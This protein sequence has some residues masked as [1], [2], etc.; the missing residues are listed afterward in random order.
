[1]IELSQTCSLPIQ[2]KLLVVVC[3]VQ[4]TENIDMYPPKTLLTF[5]PL[6][7]DSEVL[8]S[9]GY[10]SPY[11]WS[12]T[13]ICNCYITTVVDLYIDLSYP[14]PFGELDPG[15]VFLSVVNICKRRGK[16]VGSFVFRDSIW[17][18]AQGGTLT[19]SFPGVEFLV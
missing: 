3:L 11:T 19:Y 15:Y 14:R 4:K 18:K 2:Y 10:P 17:V 7:G 6:R 16:M 1:M 9:Y 12:R 8:G 13:L 5:F